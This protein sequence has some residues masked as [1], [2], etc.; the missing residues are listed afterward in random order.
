MAICKSCGKKY[1]HCTS[2]SL[3]N[4]WE[5]EY[6]CEKCWKAGY[7]YQLA[8]KITKELWDEVKNKQVIWAFMEKVAF[9]DD[10]YHQ[11]EMWLSQLGAED[12]QDR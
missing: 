9:D 6:C 10:F 2:C 8:K 4:F 11:L 1:H 5:S 3:S 12:E 7:E